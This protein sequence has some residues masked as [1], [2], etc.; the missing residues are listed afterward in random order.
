MST[1]IVAAILIGAIVAICLLLISI[2]NKQKH[3]QMNQLLNRFSELGTSHNLSFSSQNVLNNCIIGLDGINRKLLALTQIDNTSFDD[4]VVDLDEVKNCTIKK[5]YGNIKPGDLKNKKLE[6]YLERVSL[7]FDFHNGKEAIEVPF[8][9]H[10]EN[11]IYH[12]EDFEHRAEHWKQILTKML[13]GSIKKI[14]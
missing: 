13:K 4:Y 8:Y 1:I 3:K 9:E 12:L 11:S 5:H 2:A 10:A 14:A 6:T 7:H